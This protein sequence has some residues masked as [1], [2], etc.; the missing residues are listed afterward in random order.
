MYSKSMEII[1]FLLST[2]QGIFFE[3]TQV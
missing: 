1:A 2:A 3:A